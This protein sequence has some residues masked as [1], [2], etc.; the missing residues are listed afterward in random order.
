VGL[1]TLFK[2]LS[3]RCSRKTGERVKINFF[4][5]LYIGFT[6][7]IGFAAVNTGNNVLYVLLS[8]LLGLMLVSGILSRYN[9]KRLK[10]LFSPPDEVWCCKR[11]TFEVLIRNFKR[12]PSF[13]LKVEEPSLGL[14]SSVAVVERSA[15]AEAHLTFPRRG[16]FKIEKISVTSTFPFGLFRRTWEI[17]V[18]EEVLVFPKPVE[19]EIPPAVFSSPKG[20]KEGFLELKVKKFGGDTVEGLK[21]YA[22][23]GLRLIDWKTFARL[24]EFYAKE[25]SEEDV[26][27]EVLISVDDIPAT[28]GEEKISKATY[29]VLKFK[30][31]GYAVGLRFKNEEI[32]PAAGEEHFTELLRFLALAPAP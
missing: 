19:M 6:L 16:L 32:P 8:F 22:G 2:R 27:R 10:V 11:A 26:L 23:E 13:L 18:N 31:L 25:L 21:E 24:G 29:L 30:N 20:F 12:L 9:L 14:E 5:K 28:D 17:P 15:K 1:K 3:D 4:G 7:L